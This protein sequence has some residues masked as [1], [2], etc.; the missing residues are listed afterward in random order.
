METLAYFISKARCLSN[1]KADEQRIR[2][3]QA[4]KI[5]HGREYGISSAYGTHSKLLQ[6]Y[7][8]KA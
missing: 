5:L 8:G 7:H 3:E 6:I 1:A 2:L 4:S